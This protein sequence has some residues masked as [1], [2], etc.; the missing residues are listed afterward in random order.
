MNRVAVIIALSFAPALAAETPSLS[1]ATLAVA[2]SP[3]AGAAA[4]AI[5]DSATVSA[6]DATFPSRLAA[7]APGDA[8]LGDA[9]SPSRLASVSPGDATSS[10]GSPSALTPASTPAS[11]DTLAVAPAPAV[12]APVAPLAIPLTRDTLVSGLIRDL[13]A[14]YNLEGDL[15]LELIRSWEPPSEIARKWTINVIEFPAVA[16][17]TMLLRCRVS[18]DGK[19]VD[20]PTIVVRASLWRDAWATREPLMI[21]ATFEPSLLEARRVDM[22]RERDAL[23]AAVGDRSYVFARGVAAGRLLT[24]ADIGRRP[25]VKRGEMV[26]V[27]AVEGALVVTMKAIAME[28]G[29]KGDTVTVR[30]PESRKDFAAMVVDENRVQ[31]RF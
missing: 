25:L 15:Q 28:N 13:V 8:S 22:F 24:W 6:A 7:V 31:V 4:A 12:V 5:L 19:V 26:D 21:G 14:H 2:E 27:S 11:T 1:L 9:T 23:P 10:S 17:S 18:A 3:R 30:N 29:A 20:E 16:A